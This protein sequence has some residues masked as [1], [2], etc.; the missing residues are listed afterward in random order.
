MAIRHCRGNRDQ[1]PRSAGELLTQGPQ[2]LGRTYVRYTGGVIACLWIP[3]FSLSVL[4]HRR[5]SLLQPVAVHDPLES[6]VL[7]CSPEATARGVCPGMPLPRAL[8]ACSDLMLLEY[9]EARVAAADERFLQ[10]LEGIGAAVEPVRPGLALFSARSLFR[11]HGGADGVAAGIRDVFPHAESL[12]IGMGSNRFVAEVAAY[13]APGAGASGAGAPGEPYADALLIRP[14]QVREALAPLPVRVLGVPAAMLQ[15]WSALGLRTLADI[16]AID[17]HQIAD[18]FGTEGV[19]AWR[20]AQGIDDRPLRPR[21]HEATVG[22]EI[23]FPEASGSLVTLGRAVGM[24]VERALSRPAFAAHAPRSVVVVAYLVSGGS[25]CSRRVL[26]TPTL[27]AG[28]IALT[29]TAE[30]DQIPAPVERIEVRFEQLTP[31]APAQHEL[32]PTSARRTGLHDGI[33]HV[34]AALDED[35][36]LSILEVAPESRVPEHRAVLV[37]ADPRS[38]GAGHG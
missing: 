27:D 15:T 8:G 17:Q 3:R 9:D 12:R 34:Q 29:A 10:R 19:R 23:T 26:R 20:L 5:C 22:E 16:V 14:E 4:A 31:H 11:L 24:L 38:W 7:E 18:R 25:W 28:R 13:R 32:D 2:A 6:H 36:L 21:T 37:A 30:L 1:S 33:A 35:A